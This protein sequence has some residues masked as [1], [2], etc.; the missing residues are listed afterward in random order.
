MGKTTTS[1]HLAAYL[2]EK[3]PTLL[4]DADRNRSALIWSREDKLPF[5]VASQAGSTSIIRKYP[6]I[7]VDTRARPEP[8]EFKDLADGSDLLIIPTTPN[9]LDLDATFK[10]VEQLQALNANFRVLL[11]KVDARTKSGQEAKKRLREA[12]LP[13][14]KTSIPLLVV[15]EKASQRGV[16]TRD[17]SSPTSKTA[18][19][20]YEAVG[21][22]I[23]P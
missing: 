9:H 21:R 18:W 6:H 5:H 4:I 16:I 23:L 7:I 13:R 22:E 15:F 2:Q 8:E 3:A 14:F 20:A 17:Y 11:T 1:I 12:D 10:A 19:S